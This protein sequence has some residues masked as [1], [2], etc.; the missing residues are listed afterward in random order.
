MGRVI[1]VDGGSSSSSSALE[2][3]ESVHLMEHSERSTC[4]AP[5]HSLIT[6]ERLELSH[7]KTLLSLFLLNPQNQNLNSWKTKSCDVA[8]RC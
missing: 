3:G 5:G 4:P 1:M 6:N 7:K 2:T 8:Q